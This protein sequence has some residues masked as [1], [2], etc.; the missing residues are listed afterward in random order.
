MDSNKRPI[1]CNNDFINF[2]EF[3]KLTFG[4]VVSTWGYG[5]RHF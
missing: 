5:M 3:R 1:S 2:V 4:D